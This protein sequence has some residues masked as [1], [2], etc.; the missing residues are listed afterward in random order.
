MRLPRC[1]TKDGLEAEEIPALIAGLVVKAV[2][3]TSPVTPD[4][5]VTVCGAEGRKS[6]APFTVL[7]SVGPHCTTPPAGTVYRVDVPALVMVKAE[8]EL[9]LKVNRGP[10][11]RVVASGNWNVCARVP[12]RALFLELATVSTVVPPADTITLDRAK[13]L[14]IKMLAFA[15]LSTK[16]DAV[17][18]VL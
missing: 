16:L 4:P 9:L 7:M 13:E 5:Q 3:N 1:G 14:F 6:H 2:L 8:L 15:S 12:V 18:V 17:E 11:G 10:S